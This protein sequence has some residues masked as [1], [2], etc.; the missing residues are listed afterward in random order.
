MLVIDAPAGYTAG[1]HGFGSVG[2]GIANQF[3]GRFSTSV[4]TGSHTFKV[5]MNILKGYIKGNTYRNPQDVRGLPLQFAFTNGVPSAVTE[6]TSQYT[7]VDLDHDLGLFA[8]DQWSLGRL[9]VNAGLRFD[10]ITA[11]DPTIVEP[12][13]ALFPSFTAPGV[14]Q[15]ARLEGSEPAGR[16][17]LGRHG[18]RQ[19]RRQG[20]RQPV[21]HDADDIGR[22]AVRPHGELLDG[23]KLDRHEREFLSRL[24][25][26]ER[27]SQR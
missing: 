20:R 5:G 27:G 16:R 19:D 12:A 24:Q 11:H 25:P 1:Y 4:V 14:E 13:N 21:R 9:T 26:A 22:V 15:R 17:R 23:P 6:F 3:A 7:E 10:W 18:R 2:I 8:Q